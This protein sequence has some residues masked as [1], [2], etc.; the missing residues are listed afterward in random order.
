MTCPSPIT[1]SMYADGELSA[2]ETA[3]LERHAATCAACSARIEEMRRESAVLRLALQHA[4]DETPI[5]RFVPPPRARDFVVLTLAVA[6]IGGFSS[7]FWNTVGSAIPSEL[8]WLNPVVAGELYERALS[9][10]TFIVYE[11]SAMWTA[12]LNFIGVALVLAFI[13]W[14]SFAAVRQR[15]VAAIA[16]S[17]LAVVIALPSIGHAFEIR[18][19]TGLVTVEA[20]ETIDDTL[21]AAGETVSIDGNINGDLL[22]FGRSVTVRGNVTG[23]LITGG[24][25]ISVEGTIGGN[26][27]GGGRGV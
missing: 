1:H 25:T 19:N 14:V 4:E 27:I 16:A 12:A 7:A 24:E 8:R 6:I 23:D 9:V 5:P 20:G 17:L 2:R 18:R 13:A 26:V 21:L 22:A 3:S 10:L 15:G 11:G